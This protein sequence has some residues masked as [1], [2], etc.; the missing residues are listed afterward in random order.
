MNVEGCPLR[1]AQAKAAGLFTP[2]LPGSF[3]ILELAELPLHVRLQLR[4]RD[5]VDRAGLE[6]FARRAVK[7]A[8][9]AL[10]LYDRCDRW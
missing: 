3:L 10:V 8:A 2:A 7:Q 5:A 6:P 9:A 4:A 1:F